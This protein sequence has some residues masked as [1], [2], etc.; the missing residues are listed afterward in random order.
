MSENQQQCAQNQKKLIGLIVRILKR[1]YSSLYEQVLAGDSPP[2]FAKLADQLEI[3]EDIFMSEI[4]E[5][6]V[7]NI[8]KDA[9]MEKA[10]LEK[11]AV[12]LH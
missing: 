9:K 3:S 6:E 11:P 1:Q 7:N 4:I 5:Y 12:G 8:L 10:S 2:L